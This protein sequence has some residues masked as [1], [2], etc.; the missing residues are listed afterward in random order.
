MLL[1]LCP[2][3]LPHEKNEDSYLKGD[4]A[5]S[6]SWNP[7]CV[8]MSML[9]FLYRCIGGVI[10]VVGMVVSLFFPLWF[11]NLTTGLPLAYF[12]F[13]AFLASSVSGYVFN[14]KQLLV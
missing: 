3:V 1:G 8:V 4:T 7:L 5:P 12:A 9:A 14:Y 6:T 2:S 13:Y 11:G 10:G